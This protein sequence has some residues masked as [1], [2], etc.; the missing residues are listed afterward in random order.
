MQHVGLAL[1]LV[2]TVDWAAR[3]ALRREVAAPRL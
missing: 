1:A 2:P 3:A